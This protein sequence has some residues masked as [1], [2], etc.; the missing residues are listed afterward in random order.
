MEAN[1]TMK[2]EITNPEARAFLGDF[3]LKRGINREFYNLVPE[4]KFDFRMV[5]TPKRKSD[6]PREN[7]AH[8][9]DITRDYMD[10]VKTGEL[11]FGVHNKD[12]EDKP[13]PSKEKLLAELEKAE[14]ELREVLSDANIGEKKVKVPWAEAPIP[15]ISS[16]HGLAEHEVL[17][18]GLNLA[19]MDH[20]DIERFPALKQ[21]W[22]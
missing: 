18:T 13:L 14:Q 6:T 10:G 8:Q 12:R 20:L 16:L 4:D 7:L 17:H 15:A 11:R 9:V 21:M 2:S 5:D 22:G 1:E 19:L 3:M